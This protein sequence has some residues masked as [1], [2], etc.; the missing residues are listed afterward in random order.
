MALCLWLAF[1]VSKY[2][3]K[4]YVTKCLV[5]KRLVHYGNMS[6]VADSRKVVHYF[7]MYNFVASYYKLYI[8]YFIAMA[9]CTIASYY[10]I[11]HFV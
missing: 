1:L 10:T 5:S 4:R 11:L 8:H 9:M 6:S 2:S 3:I 7:Y